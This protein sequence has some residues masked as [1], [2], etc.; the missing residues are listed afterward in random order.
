[1]CEIHPPQSESA[2]GSVLNFAEWTMR[3]LFL[4]TSLLK[5]YSLRAQTKPHLS[6]GFAILYKQCPLNS[7]RSVS[8]FH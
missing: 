2:S 7:Q 3:V 4:N 6:R 8:V 5:Q 1:M